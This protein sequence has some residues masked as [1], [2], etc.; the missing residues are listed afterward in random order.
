MK[1]L[2][3]IEIL[4][5]RLDDII[6]DVF[7]DFGRGD[8]RGADTKSL[9]VSVCTAV[10]ATGY[11]SG[12][13]V[14]VLFYQAVNLWTGYRDHHRIAGGRR[15]FDGAAG[16]THRKHDSV[17]LV[18]AQCLGL[19]GG[20]QL[21]C[22]FKSTFVPAIGRHNHFHRAA[23]TGA[24]IA[25]VDPFALEVFELFDA[26]I[27]PGDHCKRLGM[28]REYSAQIFVWPFVF[29]PAGPIIGVV[30]PVG[31]DNPHIQLA[32]G[33]GVQVIDGS[34]GAFNRAADA[35]FFPALVHQSADR[36]AGGI[37]NSG[38]TAGT[39]GDELL[40]RRMRRWCA[41]ENDQSKKQGHADDDC[42]FHLNL[43]NFEN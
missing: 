38:H 39:D 23:L 20:F 14:V 17:D 26:R 21:G 5:H 36:P 25:D 42:F 40:I 35:V 31:L 32:G 41:H 2:E 9:G 13:V 19:L 12:S 18:V 30:L 27:G 11:D 16:V 22:Q 15:L 24:G 37:I 3:T 10:H 28:N 8:K 33:N 6:D 4:E 7:R 29:E 34:G 1:L 43:L